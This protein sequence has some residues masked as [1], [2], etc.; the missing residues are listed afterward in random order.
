MFVVPFVTFVFNTTSGVA[1]IALASLLPAP[2]VDKKLLGWVEFLT[3]WAG[4]SRNI[5]SKRSQEKTWFIKG[6]TTY[7]R[8]SW[9]H[10]KQCSGDVSKD[11]CT[12]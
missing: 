11:V 1:S 5:K 7:E 6:T 10:Q 2:K 8:P 9:R 4:M 3:Q 12:K